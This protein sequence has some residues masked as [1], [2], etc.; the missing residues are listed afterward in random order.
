VLIATKVRD[1]TYTITEPGS[2]NVNVTNSVCTL[3]T[4]YS[5]T[6][7]VSSPNFVATKMEN[8]NTNHSSIIYPNPAKDHLTVSFYSDKSQS[9]KIEIITLDGKKQ[10]VMNVSL[11]TGSNTQTISLNKLS[12]GIYAVRTISEEGKILFWEKFVR[13]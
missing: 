4:L 6:V 5:D 11:I 12:S 3:L 8:G 10:K 1:S 13:E 9:A 7:S 2:Y